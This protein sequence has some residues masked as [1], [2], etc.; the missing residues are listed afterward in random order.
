MS[1]WRYGILTQEYTA[2]SKCKL[3]ISLFINGVIGNDGGG[4]EWVG[5]G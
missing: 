5:S 2:Y 1:C 4:G 3:S